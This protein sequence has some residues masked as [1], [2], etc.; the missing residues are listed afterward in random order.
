MLSQLLPPPLLPLQVGAYLALE[1]VPGQQLLQGLLLAAS[2]LVVAFVGLLLAPSQRAPALLPVVA[3]LWALSFAATMVIQGM[4]APPEAVASARLFP[5]NPLLAEREQQQALLSSL[6][7]VFAAHSL[8]LAFTIKLKVSAA[9]RS[10][11]S[12]K[13]QVRA[14]A[15]PPLPAPRLCCSR[16]PWPARQLHPRALPTLRRPACRARRR[17]RA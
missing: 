6:M 17:R 13:Q 1:L 15:G 12:S 10:S 14:A 9:L 16:P 2:V 4:L 11:D 5:D 8:L 7:G 3:V